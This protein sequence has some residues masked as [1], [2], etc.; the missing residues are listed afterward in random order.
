M[1]TNTLLFLNL[2]MAIN[3]LLFVNLP[4]ALNTL[5]LL[6]LCTTIFKQIFGMYTSCKRGV[7]WGSF[8]AAVRNTRVVSGTLN[9]ILPSHTIVL[10]S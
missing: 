6:K 5:L 7:G 2:C 9:G 1:A 3:T 8:G 4:M 10:G